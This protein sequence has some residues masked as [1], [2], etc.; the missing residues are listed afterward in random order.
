MAFGYAQ[1]TGRVGAYAVVPGPGLLNSSAALATAY[2][3][4]APVLCITGQVPS[5]QIGRGFGA[6]HEI[7]DQL[8]ILRNLTKVR[9]SH[10]TPGT[11]AG[12]RGESL[13]IA[14]QR[15]QKAGRSRNGAGH[16]GNG[17]R[18]RFAQTRAGSRAD[19]AGPRADRA[20]RC[21]VGESPESDDCSRRRR[22]RRGGGTA[23]G[24]RNA[25]GAG[26]DVAQRQGCG[27]LPSLSRLARIRRSSDLA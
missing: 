15:P 22:I 7:S 1:S 9:D 25:A 3:C 19:R 13:P 24:G 8:G 6:H 2:A 20:G 5:Q 23:S 26:D 4:N 16:H 27:Q 14:F 18:G 17:S 11:G 21:P 10:R 12:R